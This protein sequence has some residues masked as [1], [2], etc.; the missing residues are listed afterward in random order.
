[1]WLSVNKIVC[2]EPC[3]I[4]KYMNNMNINYSYLVGSDGGLP[5]LFNAPN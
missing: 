4:V 2:M 5:R 1:V 3:F